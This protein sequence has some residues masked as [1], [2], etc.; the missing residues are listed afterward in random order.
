[1]KVLV[2]TVL[3]PL[4]AP[5]ADHAYYLC[6]H[7]AGCGLDVHVLTAEGGA[8]PDHPRVT[9]H[10]VMRDWS[11]RDLPRLARAVRGCSPDAALLL[12]VYHVYNHHPMITFAP[13][14][15]KAVA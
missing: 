8:A 11:W 3:P 4:M 10:P 9:A 15:A 7:L 6:E 12:Y 13:T 5:E 14:V 1:M 2:I